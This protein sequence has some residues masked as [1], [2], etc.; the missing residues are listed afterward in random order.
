MEAISNKTVSE[1]PSCRTPTE[2]GARP[3]LLN[4]ILREGVIHNHH[5]V[6]LP[7]FYNM[8]SY[9]FSKA[10]LKYYTFENFPDFSC[11]TGC[12]LFY[13]TT[14]SCRDIYHE[15]SKIVLLYFFTYLSFL[16]YSNLF[17]DREHIF[18][19]VVILLPNTGQST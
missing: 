1:G 9:L 16:P 13:A 3:T 14:E 2:R 6:L 7:V 10:H 17:E 4:R 8:N 18:F 19:I 12:P 15:T 5:Q 11:Q